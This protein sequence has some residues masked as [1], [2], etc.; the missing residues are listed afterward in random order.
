MTKEFHDNF[1]KYKQPNNAKQLL[2][3]IIKATP[4]TVARHLA[5]L[6]YEA[7][8]A[9]TT[10]TAQVRAAAE[11]TCQYLG[12]QLSTC[13]QHYTARNRNFFHLEGIEA[14]YITHRVVGLQAEDPNTSIV[15]RNGGVPTAPLPTPATLARLHREALGKLQLYLHDHLF[16]LI[17]NHHEAH[18]NIVQEPTW[19][20]PTWS[21][22]Q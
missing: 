2:H 13:R 11:D 3:I 8:T 21:F 5:D 19:K 12:E 6:V 4:T 9:I 15:L 10:L 16:L 14:E 18:N 7:T 17:H 22:S 20:L 1:A